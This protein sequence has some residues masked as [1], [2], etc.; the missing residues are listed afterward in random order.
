MYNNF[1]LFFIEIRNLLQCR[2]RVKTWNGN[3]FAEQLRIYL[4]IS[5]SVKNLWQIVIKWVKISRI[6]KQIVNN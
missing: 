3:N 2:D 6:S 5:I 4:H 1:S